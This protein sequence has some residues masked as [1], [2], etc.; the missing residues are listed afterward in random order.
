MLI[1]R[2]HLPWVALFVKLQTEG[3]SG[4]PSVCFN[5]LPFQVIF[6]DVHVTEGTTFKVWNKRKIF[7]ILNIV[8][9]PMT[10]F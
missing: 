1:N 6:T 10:Y 4:K 5:C 7:H 2:K 9:P 3:K 8:V